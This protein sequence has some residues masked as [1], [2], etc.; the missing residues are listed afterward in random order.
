MGHTLQKYILPGLEMAGGAASEV[1]APGN[2]IGIGLMG[3]GA[4]QLAGGAVGGNKGQALGGMLGGLGGGLGAAGLQGM[5]GLSGITGGGGLS[6]AMANLNPMSPG[7]NTGAA[8]AS[9]PALKGITPDMVMPGGSSM[10]P[11]PPPPSAGGQDLMKASNDMLGMAKSLGL[12]GGQ[13]QQT[14]PPQ[15]PPPMPQRPQQPPPQGGPPSG[16]PMPNPAPT[17]PSAG[18]RPPL[19]NAQTGSVAMMD[20][21]MRMMLGLQ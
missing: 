4:G 19:M 15:A 9:N 21:R 16:M 1:V 13:Q 3:S 8:L 7:F 10:P 18:M 14:Q 17:P 12:G 6:G 11:P 20:P 2:P 5:G